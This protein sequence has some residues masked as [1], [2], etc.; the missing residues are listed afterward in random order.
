MEGRGYVQ[1][2]DGQG[3][4]DMP[5][6]I[7]YG[8][9]K[10]IQILECKEGL[11]FGGMGVEY[12]VRVCARHRRGAHAVYYLSSKTQGKGGGFLEVIKCRILI[13]C[14]E[15]NMLMTSLW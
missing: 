2:N 4:G 14:Q 6:C 1:I 15:N 5:T 7:G 13:R 3:I 8:L 11:G 9:W 12:T 10:V